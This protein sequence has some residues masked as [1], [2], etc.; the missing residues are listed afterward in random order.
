MFSSFCCFFFIVRSKDELSFAEVFS[1]WSVISCGRY[2]F[3]S[4][5]DTR[6][7]VSVDP[8]FAVEKLRDGFSIRPNR[9]LE[10][11]NRR[12]GDGFVFFTSCWLETLLQRST[13]ELPG[14]LV[15]I[16][17]AVVGAVLYVS[18]RCLRP[19]SSNVALLWAQLIQKEGRRCKT[20]ETATQP[21]GRYLF[22]M[23]VSS[24]LHEIIRECFLFTFY[25]VECCTLFMSV[26]HFLGRLL[27]WATW[28]LEVSLSSGP[29]WPDWNYPDNTGLWCARPNSWLTSQARCFICH[30]PCP[31]LC[32]PFWGSEFNAAAT[33]GHVEQFLF[34]NC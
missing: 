21:R 13:K 16:L 2:S 4:S 34:F 10:E 8:V 3:L 23:S 18:G 19:T 25:S 1:W 24:S 12:N 5:V 26:K 30:V 22:G 14:G 31:Q 7:T 15:V 29:T 27:K 32:S 28:R 17:S 33:F 11:H 6:R 9:G 20:V